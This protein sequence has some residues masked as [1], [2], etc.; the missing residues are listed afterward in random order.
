MSRYRVLRTPAGWPENLPFRIGWEGHDRDYGV[1]DEFDRDFPTPEDEATNLSTGL[2]EIVPAT[3]EVTGDSR[4]FDTDKGG[5]FTKA[6]TMGEE[7]HL[8]E[9]GFVKRLPDPPLTEK[10]PRRKT[11]TE[12][13]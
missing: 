10:K 8:V 2:L 7:R 6:L 11:R 9:G 4:V 5:T 1:G 3:Y 12:K 13:E